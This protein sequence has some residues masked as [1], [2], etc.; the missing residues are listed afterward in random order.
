MLDDVQC[1]AQLNTLELMMLF[2]WLL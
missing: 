1:F 2:L